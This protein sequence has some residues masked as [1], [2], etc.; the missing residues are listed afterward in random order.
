MA[1]LLEGRMQIAIGNSETVWNKHEKDKVAAVAEEKARAS[2][3][4]KD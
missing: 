2:H 3:I 4:K 1:G